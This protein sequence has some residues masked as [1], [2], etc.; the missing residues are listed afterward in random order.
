MPLVDVTYRP[1]IPELALYELARCLPDAVSRAVECPEEPY[2]H[3]LSPGDVEVRF[4]PLGPY[5]LSG[6]DVVVEVRSKYFASRAADRQRRCDYLHELLA[7]TVADRG[8][9]VCLSL[10]TTAWAQS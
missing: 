8:L 10:P 5:D 6:L 1:D 4:R 2:D 3:P 9:G 7:D